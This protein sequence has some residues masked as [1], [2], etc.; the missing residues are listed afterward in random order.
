MNKLTSL[1][2][3]AGLITTGTIATFQSA[4][5]AASFTALDA[6]TACSLT[7]VTPTAGSFYGDPTCNVNGFTLKATTNSAITGVPAVDRNITFKE[8]AGLG[9]LGVRNGANSDPSSGEIEFDEML[10]VGFNNIGILKS[11]DLSFLY[12]PGVFNDQVFEVALVQAD[13]GLGTG[14]LRVTGASS[15]IWSFAGGTVTNLSLSSVGQGGSYRITNP[16]GDLEIA[17][18]SL[19]AVQQTASNGSTPVGGRNSDFTLSRVEVTK[20][21]EPTAMAG[22]GMFGLLAFA[23]RRKVLKAN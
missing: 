22:L 10:S 11:L 8:V 6:K 19:T 1:S 12:R 20:V 5:A 13:G 2:L 17:G 18:F 16:F 4:A 7:T 23:R 3:L 14:T 21:P 9:G 15:A